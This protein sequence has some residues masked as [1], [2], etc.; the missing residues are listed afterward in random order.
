MDAGALE[1]LTGGL[2]Q[3]AACDGAGTGDVGG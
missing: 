3:D 2:I 1:I